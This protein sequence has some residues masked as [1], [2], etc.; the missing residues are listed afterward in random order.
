MLT[1]ISYRKYRRSDD[2][3]GTVLY[4]AVMVA[5]VQKDILADISKQDTVNRVLDP[6]HGSGTALY[7]SHLVFPE[8]EILGCDINPLANLITKS[9]LTGVT[10]N[11]EADIDSI[12]RRL[13]EDYTGPAL[14]FPNR[15]KWFRDDIALSLTQI[16]DAIR[17]VTTRE[18]RLF[19]WCMM[20]DVVRRYSNSRSS[21]YKL[22]I[23]PQERID[24]MPNGVIADFLR[25]IKANYHQY[26]LVHCKNFRLFKQDALLCLPQF[27]CDNRV[28][29]LITSPPYG[30]NQTTVPY[31]LFSSL[32][33][34]W[35]D[36]AD[37]DLEGWELDNY[38]VIDSHSL[39]SSAKRFSLNSF[40]TDLLNQYISG[41]S[42]EKTKK[43]KIFFFDYF[44][45]LDLSVETVDKYIVLTVGNRTVDRVRIDM[46]SITA[47]Y[48]RAKGF[49]EHQTVSR[50]IM[51][52]RTP[53]LTSRVNDAPV[54]SMGKEYVLIYKNSA[55]MPVERLNTPY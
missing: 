38:S 34:R 10:R 40:Q 33:L 51:N 7:E 25:S 32:A 28:D 11:I 4:P 41:I 43:V 30:D 3:H 14:D 35:I 26:E 46:A 55:Q 31:G 16:R 19:F 54:E 8:A 52:K 21:T 42:E 49:I 20:S 44:R 6:F 2:I 39:G 13:K 50:N 45:F 37:L 36:P 15:N 17:T 1:D 47:S 48:L 9:K 23:K 24:E 5:P 29:V 22:H 18:N 53:P 27:K 12:S